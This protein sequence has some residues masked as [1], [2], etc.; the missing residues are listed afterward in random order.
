MHKWLLVVVLIVLV[1]LLTFAH[2]PLFAVSGSMH[3]SL[4]PQFDPTQWP[5]HDPMA[6]LCVFD[7]ATTTRT[8]KEPMSCRGESDIC[9][10]PT[11]IMCLA[12]SYVASDDIR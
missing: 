8:L 3:G 12:T 4:A 6:C 11:Y 5:A 10:Y 7:L 2:L 1:N 9:A